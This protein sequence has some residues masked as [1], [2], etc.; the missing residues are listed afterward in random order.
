MEN[1]SAVSSSV[2]SWVRSLS[3]WSRP[4]ASS[5]I[6]RGNS[7]RF[8]RLVRASASFQTKGLQWT[9]AG[10]GPCPRTVTRPAE[11]TIRKDLASSIEQNAIHGSD[12]PETA[13]F[14]IGYFFSG[15][16]LVGA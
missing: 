15:L 13:A 14:E 3:G 10:P 5:L 4:E 11:R 1:A 12:A 6:A 2:L 8:T 16:E 9:A 7:P